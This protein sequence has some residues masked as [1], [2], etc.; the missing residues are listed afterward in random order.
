MFLL[1]QTEPNRKKSTG[2]MII[3]ISSKKNWDPGIG[4]IQVLGQITMKLC[5]IGV[6]KII[7]QIDYLNYILL[8]EILDLSTWLN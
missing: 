4:S 3:S 6:Y 1:H 8:G 7:Y 5:I 2:Q